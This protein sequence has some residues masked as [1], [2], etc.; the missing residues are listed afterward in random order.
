MV[1]HR[2]RLPLDLE[3][4]HDLLGVHAVLDDLERNPAPYRLGLLGQVHH[5]H[6]ALAE[7]FQDAVGADLRRRSGSPSGRRI[8]NGGCGRF[9]RLWPGFQEALRVGVGLQQRPHRIAH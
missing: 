2:Q 1:H 9:V 6:S 5:A 7:L 3:A 8:G 4:S